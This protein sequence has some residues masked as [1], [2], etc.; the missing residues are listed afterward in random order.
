MSW[1][2][3]IKQQEAAGQLSRS[4]AQLKTAPDG[5]PFRDT[6][7]TNA[8]GLESLSAKARE[9]ILKQLKSD[10]TQASRS[11]TLAI[12]IAVVLAILALA[13]WWGLKH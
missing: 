13:F 6:F 9:E 2:L 1:R 10:R 11:R 4:K 5:K 12:V 7:T 3:G 8:V